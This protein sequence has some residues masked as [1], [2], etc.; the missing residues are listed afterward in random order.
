ML[1]RSLEQTEAELMKAARA[2]D[3]VVKEVRQ[4]EEQ[5]ERVSRQANA[6]ELEAHKL[7]SDRLTAEKGALNAKGEAEKTRQH[8]IEKE[9][10]GAQMQ[11]ELA[12]VR[13]DTLNVTANNTQLEV[14]VKQVNEE[15]KEQDALVAKYEAESRRR[16][17]EIEKK[18]HEID[19]LNKKFEQMMAKRAGVEDLDED[20]GPLEAAIV[21]I[22]KDI[23][24]KQAESAE[25][26]RTWIKGQ[27]ELVTLQNQNAGVAEVLADRKAK[28][29]ILEQKRMRCVHRPAALTH[30]PAPPISPRSSHISGWTRSTS[31]ASRRCASSGARRTT[32]TSRWGRSTASSTSTP[33]SSRC[34]PTHSD[35]TLPHPTHRS[36]APPTTTTQVLADDNYLMEAEFAQKLK[37][38]EVEAVG[39]EAK[40]VALKQ[41]KEGMLVDTTEAQKQAALLEKKIALERET[42]KA[43]DPEV[44]AAEVRAMQ[45]EI[46]RMRLRYAQLQKRQ[47]LMIQDMERAIYKRDNIEAK[48][49]TMAGKKGAP[50]T[51][52]ALAKQLA[53][54]TKKLKLTTHDANLSQMAVLKLQQTQAERGAQV[55][56]AAAQAAAAEAQAAAAADALGAQQAQ[57][58]AIALQLR[59][60]SRLASKL[61]AAAEGTYAPQ[62]SEAEIEALTAENEAT[63]QRLMG[64][65]EA[66]AASFPQQAPQI[67]SLVQTVM[68]G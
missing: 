29:A 33:R 61:V 34:S 12:R 4:L 15:I 55:D 25:L 16:H 41:E 20:A 30:H 68:A 49:K 23:A 43:L 6:T 18:Q 31:R 54:L 66:L 21:H 60:K 65:V 40:I 35:S 50:P 13:V 10:M 37:G 47:E 38:L 39:I 58:R 24:A 7:V 2:R 53:E 57:A 52:A 67:S 26:Q 1:A 45:R 32:C 56:E 44:G 48:G 36:P 59:H 42:Q 19:L 62:Q 27:T 28:L 9:A 63:A 11:N 64:V 46:H 17:T 14:Q 3:V 5:W 22:K 8:V 51:S